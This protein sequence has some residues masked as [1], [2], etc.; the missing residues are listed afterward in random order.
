MPPEQ[1][2]RESPMHPAGES[3]NRGG[4]DSTAAGKRWSIFAHSTGKRSELQ[5][6]CPGRNH[7]RRGTRETRPKNKEVPGITPVENRKAGDGR[8][9][10]PLFATAP[11]SDQERSRITREFGSYEFEWENVPEFR[12]ATAK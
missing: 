9:I 12:T 5:Q 4:Q 10:L 3:T 6:E 11:V 7:H 1:T 8:P 2:V